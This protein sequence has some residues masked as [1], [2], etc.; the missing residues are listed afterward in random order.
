MVIINFG[1]PLTY[2]YAT[3][4]FGKVWQVFDISGYCNF[5]I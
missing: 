5:A 3:I 4:R 2:A 1:L